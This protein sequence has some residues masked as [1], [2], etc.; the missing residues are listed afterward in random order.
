MSGQPDGP[1]VILTHGWGASTTE[2][3]YLRRQLAGRYR[4]VCWDLP[5]LGKSRSPDDHNFSLDKLAAD[6]KSVL[7]EAGG[8][9]PVVLAGHSI[10]GMI[11]LNFA[12][13]YPQELGARVSG[14]ALVHTTPTNP[15]KTTE[16]IAILTPI[17]NLVLTPMAYAMIGLSPMVW[18]M[19]VLSYLNGSM[20]R[21]TYKDS[22]SKAGTWGQVEF[23]SRYVFQ[24]WPATYARGML[25][26]LRYD[27]TEAL[28]QI[29]IPV[30]VVSGDKDKV[31]KPEASRML[32]DGISSGELVTL[33]PAGHFGLLSSHEEF[34]R[35]I[36]SFLERHLG[37]KALSPVN[38]HVAEISPD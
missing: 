14:L 11:T 24:V 10:G 18:I 6:L 15:V 28:S 17:Q 30:L 16:G 38:V 8:P 35:A 12:K 27:A 32:K 1:T 13:N 34:G 31:C 9:A 20:H 26:M 29:K 4:L 25:G 33:S 23:V 3:F 21:S 22:F 2:W 5:G 37:D 19:N 36:E 7:D